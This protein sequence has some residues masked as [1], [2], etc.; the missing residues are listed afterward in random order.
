MKSVILQLILFVLFINQLY[1]KE[2]KAIIVIADN[3]RNPIHNGIA[4]SVKRDWLTVRYFIKQLTKY[5]ILR[6]SKLIVL[7]GQNGSLNNIKKVIKNIKTNKDDVLMFYFSGHGGQ[8]KKNLFLALSDGSLLYKRKL[9]KLIKKKKAK[10]KIIITDSCST[11][12]AGLPEE[13]ALPQ[14]DMSIKNLKLLFNQY[15]GLLYITAASEGEYAWGNDSEGGWFTSSLF[16]KVLLQ[17]TP[18]SWKTV[19]RRTRN[20]TVKKF[21]SR[22]TGYRKNK[23]KGRGISGQ[24][25]KVY[26]LPIFIKDKSFKLVKKLNAPYSVTATEGEYEKKVKIFWSK[27]K[28]A[29]S[30]NI[31]RW[32][33]GIKKWKSIGKSRGILYVDYDVKPNITYYYM[34]L[35]YN[36]K[37]SSPYSLHTKGW[38]GSN[39]LKKPTGLTVSKGIYSKYIKLKWDKVPYAN[40]YTLFKWN[41][42]LKKWNTF[43]NIRVNYFIDK[44]VKQN[45]RYIYVLVAKNQRGNSPYSR[46]VAGWVKGAKNKSDN[47]TFW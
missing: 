30:Y 22:I 42:K 40:S 19:A 38:I 24:H 41:P 6:T 16:Q 27:V 43:T 4:G 8:Y 11:S 37:T 44:N 3:Y 47:G 15:K 9:E 33:K 36:N 21:N 29:T 25:P 7:R 32:Y 2:L 35:A 10:L 5:K 45:N 13:R 31:F 39:T 34:V 20:I 1:G 46:Y 26:S 23:L 28:G 18:D 12:I 14:T 17:N